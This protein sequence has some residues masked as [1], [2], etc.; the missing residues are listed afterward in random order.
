[1]KVLSDDSREL[2]LVLGT[3][4]HIDHGKTSLVRALTGTDCDRLSE[5]K[6]RGITIELGFAS[7][8]LADGRIVSIVDVPGHER[9]IRQMVAGAAG[10]DAVLFVVAADEGVMPQTREHLEIL[11]L[12][13]IR[14]GI[15]ALTK[16]DAV[17][18]DLLEL[19]RMDVEAL[20]KGTFL[21]GAAIVP[22]SSV[23]GRGIDALKTE[24]GRLV[25]ELQPRRWEGLFFLPIDRAFPISGFGT[26]VTGTAY[27]GRIR[28][29][30]EVSILPADVRGKVRSLQVH[31]KA[32]DVASA[33]QRVAL[34]L[35][36]ISIDSLEK[37]DVLCPSDLFEPTS[38]I[39][40]SFQ[41][42]PSAAEPLRHWQRI[43]LHL[44]TSD[45]LARISFLDRSEIHAGERAVAQLVTESPLVGLLGQPF[46]VRF[47]SPLKT[48]GGG[49]ILNVY[50]HKPRGTS[51]RRERLSWL[52]D[53]EERLE[54]GKSLL[55][56]FVDR[57]GLLPLPEAVRLL[58]EVPLVLSE[59]AQESPSMTLLR[60]GSEYLLS[61][62]WMGSLEGRAQRALGA[63]HEEEPFLEG[64]SPERLFREILPGGDLK[65]LKALGKLLVDKG[66]V[67]FDE[68]LFRLPSFVPT[69]NELF[70]ERSEKLL[71]LCRERKF[72]FPEIEEAQS[73]LGLP[74]TEFQSLLNALRQKKQV[75]ILAE[76]FLLSE[77]VEEEL[78]R[79]V[80]ALG[81]AITLASVRDLTGSTR[82]F[83]LPL[84]EYWDSRGITRR[85]G[86]K[87]ILL[88]K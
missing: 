85:V 25:D 20:L 23:D 2:S 37:G 19:A 10:I 43:R 65:L 26:V 81:G 67:C 71:G 15:V 28:L 42:L 61:S 84:L 64:L 44:G 66:T 4:G 5:E 17:D 58:Q 30:E 55:E 1:M 80:A 21:E 59:A 53:V 39:D 51:A 46:V 6:K 86:D 77:E 79:Q 8:R 38:C 76:T 36:G 3:A 24:I 29:G 72:Q 13:G 60:A 27:S 63:F 75:A 40:V 18:D 47:Y 74:V 62:R 35:A 57:H 22:L 41:L 56:V 87:R 12:L 88:K 52:C 48:I 11:S 32:V 68:G 49:R 31:G 73:L 83:V 45:V 33:G 70:L 50:G 14:R 78:L 34:N 16:I 9:F 82:R 69:R 54:A 7:L